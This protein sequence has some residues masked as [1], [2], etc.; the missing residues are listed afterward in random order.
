MRNENRIKVFLL[1]FLSLSPIMVIPTIS[2]AS[3]THSWIAEQ[4]KDSI[5]SFLPEIEAYYDTISA[6]APTPESVNTWLSFPLFT[7]NVL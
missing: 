3:D 1:L 4:V 2:W 5:I 7:S 6:Y